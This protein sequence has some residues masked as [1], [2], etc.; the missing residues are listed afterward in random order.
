MPK[1]GFCRNCAKKETS[2]ERSDY[3][4]KSYRRKRRRHHL[5]LLGR[6]TWAEYLGLTHK[7][8]HPIVQISRRRPSPKPVRGLR[9][10]GSKK[11]P[12]ASNGKRYRK[13]NTPKT[14]REVTPSGPAGQKISPETVRIVRRTIIADRSSRAQSGGTSRTSS[15]KRSAEKKARYI[16]TTRSAT[17]PGRRRLS[18]KPMRIVRRT[19]YVYQSKPSQAESV[20]RS[21]SNASLIEKR[22]ESLSIHNDE[23]EP[24]RFDAD[25]KPGVNHSEGYDSEPGKKRPTISH[26]KSLLVEPS[27]S[28][29]THLRHY[30]DRGRA[31]YTE[32]SHANYTEGFSYCREPFHV[33]DLHRSRT[34]SV[35]LIRVGGEPDS[36]LSSSSSAQSSPEGTELVSRS[37]SRSARVLRGPSD[38][39]RSRPQSLGD[40][41]TASGRGQESRLPSRSTRVLRINP[42]D[43]RGRPQSP[44]NNPLASES[45]RRLWPPSRSARVFR[46]PSDGLRSRP[47]SSRN[48]P[49]VSE[50]G[51]ELRSPSRSVRVL[52]VNPDGLH[53]R[54]QSPKD[55]R[56]P[57]EPERESQPPSRSA[58]VFRVNPDG[59]NSR[60]QFP[61]IGPA[62]SQS[63]SES[64]PPS[65]SVRVICVQPDVLHSRPQSPAMNETASK[66]DQS[67]LAACSDQSVRA[68]PGGT[69]SRPTSAQAI[70]IATESYASRPPSRS[71][72]VLRVQPDGL[73]SRPQSPRINPTPSQSDVSLHSQAYRVITAKFEGGYSRPLSPPPMKS[74]TQFYGSRPPSQSDRIVRVSQESIRPRSRSRDLRITPLAAREPDEPRPPYSSVRIRRIPNQ[75]EDVTSHEKVSPDRSS[76][77]PPSRLPSPICASYSR[78]GVKP[79][80]IRQKRTRYR[81][82]ESNSDSFSTRKLGPYLP[83]IIWSKT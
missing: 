32:S 41:P 76:T 31:P 5:R 17:S 1:L 69:Y 46:V 78:E 54:P 19:T 74:L 37:P 15:R 70:Q 47:K 81:G 16:S 26:V 9:P 2:S 68:R 27:T 49:P 80:I 72:R 14:S 51:R 20:L 4:N 25:H 33:E 22:V 56:A 60:P 59:F 64:R 50:P 28:Q 63:G 61:K 82:S 79:R 12:K 13:N 3:D 10:S 38:G 77:K 36:L 65:Q 52:H 45:R 24:R 73:R 21:S 71:V 43:L 40:D 8:Y 11:P 29:S 6:E 55:D 30:F 62:A 66:S 35:R 83:I 44:S 58:R 34:R 53:S 42:N 75:V 18:P 39:L 48:S 67:L 57:S 7:S 23:G